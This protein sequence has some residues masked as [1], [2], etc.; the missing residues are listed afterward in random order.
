MAKKYPNIQTLEVYQ[1]GGDTQQVTPCPDATIDQDLNLDNRER[2]ISRFNY[3]KANSE[4]KCGNCILFDISKRMKKC[5]GDNS[6]NTGYCWSNDFKCSKENVCDS[7]EKGGPLKKDDSSYSKQDQYASDYEESKETVEQI[8]EGLQMPGLNEPAVAPQEEMVM[9]QQ[10]PEQS[11]QPQQA[12]IPQQQMPTFEY[13]GSLRRFQDDGDNDDVEGM[14]DAETNYPGA[15]DNNRSEE[16]IINEVE[17]EVAKADECAA[18]G[19]NY[20]SLTGVCE[21]LDNNTDIFDAKNNQENQILNKFADW[22]TKRGKRRRARSNR[23]DTKPFMMYNAGEDTN[24]LSDVINLFQSGIK[25]FQN[26]DVDPN[27]ITK[28]EFRNFK[29]V[30]R[31]QNPDA[32]KKEINQMAKNIFPSA[33]NNRWGK[34]NYQQFKV[35]NPFDETRFFDPTQPDKL[36]TY[37]EKRMN[38][39]NQY[40]N[41]RT[42]TY[43]ELYQI[44][45]MD[46]D[47]NI[48]YQGDKLL[49]DMIETE[50]VPD[51]SFLVH[52]EDNTGIQGS[53]VFDGVDERGQKKYKYI[54]FDAE[55]PTNITYE[56]SSQQTANDCFELQEKCAQLTPPGD[57]DA[58]N[59]KC[60]EPTSQE[61]NNESVPEDANLDDMEFDP[62]LKYGGGIPTYAYMRDG[63]QLAKH[64]IKSIVKHSDDISSG[65]KNLRN[66]ISSTKKISPLYTAPINTSNYLYMQNMPKGDIYRKSVEDLDDFADVNLGAFTNFEQ[67][68]FNKAF[69]DYNLGVDLYPDRIPGTTSIFED[70]SDISPLDI[71]SM[72]NSPSSIKYNSLEGNPILGMTNKYQL[73][74]SKSSAFSPAEIDI[75]DVRQNLISRMKTTEG[76]LRIKQN[77]LGPNATEQDVDKFITSFTQIPTKQSE[78]SF[79][80]NI[81][82]DSQG[83]WYFQPQNLTTIKETG[84]LPYINMNLNLPSNYLRNIWRHESQHALDDLGN[85]IRNDG[86]ANPLQNFAA[87]YFKTNKFGLPNDGIQY[88]PTNINSS[89][90]LNKGSILNDKLKMKGYQPV[91]SNDAVMGTDQQAMQDYLTGAKKEKHLITEPTAHIAEL[92]QFMMDKKIIPDNDY[93]KVTTEMIKDMRNQHTL[94]DYPMRIFMATKDTPNNNKIIASILNKMLTGTALTTALNELEMKKDGG[95]L[96]KFQNKNEWSDQQLLTWLQLQNQMIQT[97]ASGSNTDDG[98]IYNPKTIDLKDRSTWPGAKFSVADGTYNTLY[99]WLPDMSTKEGVSAAYNLHRTA[100]EKFPQYAAMPRTFWGADESGQAYP[101]LN[102]SVSEKEFRTGDFANYVDAVKYLYDSKNTINPNQLKIA[103]KEFTF[104]NPAD[105]LAYANEFNIN[106]SDLTVQ[107][108]PFLNIANYQQEFNESGITP[109]WNRMNA[110]KSD[111]DISGMYYDAN[112]GPHV[113]KLLKQYEAEKK[114]SGVDNFPPFQYWLTDTPTNIYG[115]P[116]DD[117]TSN[118]GGGWGNDKIPVNKL[119]NNYTPDFQLINKD[120]AEAAIKSSFNPYFEGSMSGYGGGSLG[121]NTM[122]QEI[123]IDGETVTNP[124]FIDYGRNPEM[125]SLMGY[126]PA[127]VGGAGALRGVFQG[128]KY[129]AGLTVPGSA[130]VGA[131]VTFGQLNNAYW[132]QNAVRNTLPEAY[133][134][135]SEGRTG[136]GFGNL[137]MGALEL[138]GVGNTGLV[139]VLPKNFNQ[140]KT[141]NPTLPALNQKGVNFINSRLTTPS[142]NINIPFSK[143]GGKDF[144]FKNPIGSFVDKTMGPASSNYKLPLFNVNPFSKRPTQ[145]DLLKQ[146][147][148]KD[149]SGA[150]VNPLYTPQRLTTTPILDLKQTGGS[151]YKAQNGSQDVAAMY[152]VNPEQFDYEAGMPKEGAISSYGDVWQ[153]GQ[154][155]DATE[156]NQGF[157]TPD[158]DQF[159]VV[160][161]AFSDETGTINRNVGSMFT[162]NA[163][164]QGMKT[165]AADTYDVRRR[166]IDMNTFKPKEGSI[167]RSYGDVF[168]TE[169]D[170]FV[171]QA[172]V[173][174][175]FDVTDDFAFEG[176]GN[177][178]SRR[179]LRNVRRNKRREDKAIEAGFESYEDMQAAKE[180]EKALRKQRRQDRRDRWG[181]TFGQRM[182]NKLNYVRDSKVVQGIEKGAKFLKEAA[183]IGNKI[184]DQINEGK[185][186]AYNLATRSADDAYSV[187][188]ADTLSRGEEDENVGLMFGDRVISRQDSRSQYGSELP[189]AQYG[190]RGTRLTN[191]RFGVEYQSGEH[192]LNLFFGTDMVNCWG[193]SCRDSGGGRFKRG[194]YTNFSPFETTEIDNEGNSFNKMTAA[195]DIGARLR[196]DQD[197]YGLPTP[198]PAGIMLEGYGGMDFNNLERVSPYY[199]GR[200][201]LQFKTPVPQTIY[202]SGLGHIYKDKHDYVPQGQLDLF[203]D[204]KSNEGLKVGA[205]ARYGLLNA[206][207]SYNPSTSNW[208]YSGGLGFFFKDGGEQEEKTV[209]IDTDMYYELLAAGADIE[210]I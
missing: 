19:G 3:G 68:I 5:I 1:E 97:G 207:V 192:P 45:N 6:G 176:D 7:Y 141:L 182:R 63:G 126:I 205:Q 66:F 87:N 122:N 129:L 159:N 121:N 39:Y 194:V 171:D 183:G 14:E 173:T 22:Q 177:T 152:M 49:G 17:S 100:S 114:A 124:M 167:N 8:Q 72:I 76:R 31:E 28:K 112:F 46:M 160:G 210:I 40:A 98:V 104:S 113:E 146:Y 26:F 71:K 51:A 144:S 102:E 178:L 44:S 127:L 170:M 118:F 41:N 203:A 103:G 36:I 131:P 123:M 187:M 73:P 158:S 93:T 168:N 57:W 148:N 115:K 186:Q 133:T 139:N 61:T 25:D 70:F 128:A 140:L 74:F 50:Y 198:G 166:D 21:G 106:P 60:N 105:A 120:N 62:D 86:F 135:F 202:K 161:D 143:I 136:E 145:L 142:P 101:Y 16:D 53:Y 188:A 201:G 2:A 58:A 138:S 85:L 56:K 200:A 81:L 94:S 164:N 24:I 65:V 125:N 174:P 96:T 42:A 155:V 43:P 181:D 20:N 75:L 13:G 208:E 151:L 189:N 88:M 77:Y 80:Q 157:N 156:E 163:V 32:S 117:V 9:Q 179:Q 165:A 35:T 119:T 78:A 27:K 195:G 59:C 92:Q 209:S 95:S 48:T 147:T 83:E 150:V 172:N 137:A 153:G 90:F 110:K 130:A 79:N 169:Q 55:N 180:E 38:E 34:E 10:A 89:L 154:W 116:I 67:K 29:K 107:G 15:E 64:Q 191:P 108:N 91:Q 69:N 18:R 109:E 204:Y 12:M 84:Q 206:G 199:G 37:E 197:F 33:G 23:V 82:F 193:G 190:F 175:E 52:N 132:A 196:L 149:F 47:G 54:P 11:M 30:L 162:A 99:D 134:D 185:E 4:D 184:F 111:T